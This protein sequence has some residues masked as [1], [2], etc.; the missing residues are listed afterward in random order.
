M[1]V[2]LRFMT[3]TLTTPVCASAKPHYLCHVLPCIPSGTVAVGFETVRHHEVARFHG[4]R[5]FDT[6][7]DIF[8]A[9]GLSMEKNNAP[10]SA[11]SSV[12]WLAFTGVPRQS[13][14]YRRMAC[15]CYDG[16]SP[17]RGV[18]VRVRGVAH[19]PIAFIA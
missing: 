15:G 12:G 8:L 3:D 13:G 14:D 2:K 17:S 6:R 5:A 1:W 18:S 19:C 10:T 4:C 11:P 7:D 16:L 9:H